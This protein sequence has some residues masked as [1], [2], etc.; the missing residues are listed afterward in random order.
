[1]QE[2]FY[3]F[4]KKVDR[5]VEVHR[6]KLLVM[7]MFFVA[8]SILID[9]LLLYII[10]FLTV[11]LSSSIGSSDREGLLSMI[12]LN[13]FMSIVLVSL[14]IFLGFVFYSLIKK[15]KDLSHVNR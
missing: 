1:M 13:F 2:K 4:T 3:L 7:E 12:K 14:L 8:L 6:K 11:Y 10:C 15:M 5:F 9:L